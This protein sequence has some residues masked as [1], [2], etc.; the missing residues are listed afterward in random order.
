MARRTAG[1]QAVP[2][3][4]S[5]IAALQNGG[6]TKELGRRAIAYYGGDGLTALAHSSG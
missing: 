3:V 1:R 6:A 5:P 2:L 4:A